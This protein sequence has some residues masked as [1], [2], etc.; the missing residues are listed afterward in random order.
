MTIK[1][2]DLIAASS[3]DVRA[4]YNS[5]AWASDTT[6]YNWAGCYDAALATKEGCGVRYV[7]FNIPQYS[8]I[9]SCIITFTASANRSLTTVNSRFTGELDESATFS[10]IV[11]YQG[12]RGTIVGGADDTHITTAQVN[13][14]NI[15]AWTKDT[16]YDSP[17]LSIILQEMVNARA[18]KDLV[19]WWDDH[20]GRSTQG[21]Q[22][23]RQAYQWGAG[24]RPLLTVNFTPY[25]KVWPG[26]AL[27][28][29]SA[30]II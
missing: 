20:D 28:M 26:L 14:D 17:D 4:Y 13:W 25:Y 27:K 5:A 24:T 9:N 22:R 21:A 23:V 12:R 15:A 7:N 11:N 16:T 6:G 1:S 18:I 2:T 3:D 10:N 8:K 30:G 29:Q 19:F